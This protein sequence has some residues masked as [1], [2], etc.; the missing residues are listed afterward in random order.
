MKSNDRRARRRQPRGDWELAGSDYRR[1]VNTRP[2]RPQG[3]LRPIADCLAEVIGYAM[4]Q[5]RKHP[6]EG[7]AR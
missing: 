4:E 7:P 1:D 6:A 5:E 2:V 3:G